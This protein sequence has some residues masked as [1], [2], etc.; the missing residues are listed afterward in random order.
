M[1]ALLLLASL[2]ATQLP[3]EVKKF[4]PVENSAVPAELFETSSACDYGEPEDCHADFLETGKAWLGDLNDDGVEELLIKAS[5]KLSG[6]GG[7][8]YFLY[9][10]EPQGWEPLTEQDGWVTL[11]FGPRFDIF[12]I[13]RQGY[14]DIRVAIGECWKWDGK[15]YVPYQPDDYR[16]LSPEWF[17]ASDFW[18]QEIFWAIRYRGLKTARFEPVWFAGIPEWST[19][20]ELEDKE[21]DLRWIATLKGGVYGV[22]GNRSFL[23]LPRPGYAGAGKLELNGDWL[24]IHGQPGKDSQPAILIRYNRR[25]GELQIEK[26]HDE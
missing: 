4:H 3:A 20:D 12:P 17:N 19:N 5:D 21:Y 2:S 13:V 25:T 22:Q 24:V 1:L 6:T 9:Q 18:E 14:H 16:E 15:V 10:K 7:D 23:L 8:V 11:T 26:E